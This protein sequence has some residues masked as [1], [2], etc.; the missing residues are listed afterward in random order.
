[1]GN[2]GGAPGV[3]ACCIKE[4]ADRHEKKVRK[5]AEGQFT[6]SYK[7]LNDVWI[8]RDEGDVDVDRH[9]KKVRKEAEGQFTARSNT[10]IKEPNC[11]GYKNLND[12]W[13]WRGEGRCRGWVWERNE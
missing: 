7:N 5:E 13:I 3:L 8:W 4:N 12:V 11:A 6:A 1:M 2:I 9:E 10:H